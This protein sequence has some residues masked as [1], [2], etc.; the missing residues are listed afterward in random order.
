M[1][2][3]VMVWTLCALCALGLTFGT[4]GPASAQEIKIGVLAPLTGPASS[5]GEYTRDAAELAFIGAVANGR[6]APPQ[7]LSPHVVPGGLSG[8]RHHLAPQSLA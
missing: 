8:V 3:R 4:S 2:A 6:L 1:T 5:W 7:R